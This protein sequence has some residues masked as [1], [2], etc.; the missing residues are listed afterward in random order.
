[1]ILIIYFPVFLMK[2]EN[3]QNVRINNLKGEIVT[4]NIC[5]PLLRVS[6]ELNWRKLARV[7]N[8]NQMVRSFN[9]YDCVYAV[10]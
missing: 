2:P 6:D 4:Q 8:E 1:M 9:M 3:F 7:E 10:R 5:N